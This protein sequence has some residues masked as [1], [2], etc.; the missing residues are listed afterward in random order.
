MSRESSRGGLPSTEELTEAAEAI[1]YVPS[2]IERK[3]KAKFWAKAGENPL[4]NLNGA[5]TTLTQVK[6]IAGGGTALDACWKKPGFKDWFM[7]PDD[8]RAK[9]E[10]LFD[11]GLDAMEELLL[12]PDP[13]TSAAKV[14]ALKLLSELTGRYIKGRQGQ[15]GGLGEAIAGAD[16]ASLEALFQSAGLTVTVSASKGHNADDSTTINVTPNKEQP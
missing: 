9:L 2:T 7:N 1:I 16:K 11:L 14:N 6:Q 13:K 10:Y 5:T 4:L 12:N 8:G 15:V 3:I